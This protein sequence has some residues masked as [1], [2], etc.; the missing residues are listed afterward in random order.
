MNDRVQG[1]NDISI[2]TICNLLCKQCV[3]NRRILI[4]A[5]IREYHFRIC[6]L[7]SDKLCAV[8]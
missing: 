1:I 7:L 3:T 6:F 4:H 8:R 5:Y 2:M